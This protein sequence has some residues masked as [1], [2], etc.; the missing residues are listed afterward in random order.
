M[1]PHDYSV[2]GYR[3]VKNST[4]WGRVINIWEEAYV[5]LPVAWNTH[6]MAGKPAAILDYESYV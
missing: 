1:W 2:C 4:M 5:L 6:V 3:Y